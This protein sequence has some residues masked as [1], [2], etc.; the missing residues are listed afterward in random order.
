MFK[1]QWCLF[2][3]LLLVSCSVG[4]NYQRPQTYT[5]EQLISSIYSTGDN[6]MQLSK[7]WYK[8]FNDETLNQLINKALESAPDI[9]SAKEKLR[10][11]R[12]NLNIA[13]ASFG[14]DISAKGSYSQSD[15]FETPDYKNKTSYYQVGFDAAW[16]LDI[17]G[18]TRRLTES[19][20]AL[21]QAAS[22]DLD[23]VRLILT[24]EI[25]TNYIN[26][27]Q[28]EKLLQITQKNL[29]L[30]QNIFAIVK[31]KHANGLA[32]NL[33]LEQAKS[34]LLLTDMQIAPLKSYITAYQNALSNLTG[35]LPHQLNLPSSDIL[36]TKPHLDTTDINK[37]SASVI[38][39]RP[40]VKIAEQNLIAQNA[41]IGNN[42]ANL[43]PSISLSS[44]LGWQNTSLA[45][46]ISPS[47]QIYSNESIINL[48]LLNW[49]RLLNQVRLQESKT[50]QAV[51]NY[52]KSI[53]A[54]ISD[55]NTSSQNLEQEIIRNQA[56]FKNQN[57]QSKILDLS[58]TKYKNGLIEF[59]D[60]LTAEQNKLKA[61]QDY[62]QSL[63]SIYI[64]TISLNK[65]LG[66]GYTSNHSSHEHQTDATN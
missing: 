21:L 25:A 62:I 64:N 29:E 8:S 63:S 50:K 34:A 58:L 9:A 15:T 60:V 43:F 27:R 33:A 11:A 57:T 45:P 31:Q 48:P 24:S 41:L 22:S 53:L 12:I 13:R 42:L 55:L 47:Y 18:K 35:I 17:W 46:I 44:F 54:A 14:P 39:N 3:I 40:D 52:Q 65:A 23:N 59:S 30:Q 1:P 61:E 28:S 51:I 4:P 32:D 5:D 6:E 37:I 38:R 49:N 19:T 26:Y 20:Q 56:A 7:E 66:G 16:E 36:N 10:Q 2:S